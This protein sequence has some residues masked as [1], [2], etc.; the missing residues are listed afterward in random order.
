MSAV[1]KGYALAI[2]FRDGRPAIEIRVSPG[3]VDWDKPGPCSSRS[4]HR[5]HVIQEISVFFLAHPT[6]SRN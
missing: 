6:M 2:K 1:L 5:Q 4:E 3:Q